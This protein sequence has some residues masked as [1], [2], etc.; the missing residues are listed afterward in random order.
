MIEVEVRMSDL[1]F[2]KVAFTKLPQGALAAGL[3]EAHRTT[4]DVVDGQ[5]V[6]LRSDDDGRASL[7]IRRAVEL[8][9]ICVRS[10]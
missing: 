2:A 5:P 10:A 4:S 8:G 3:A 7:F 1:G 6:Y 9:A